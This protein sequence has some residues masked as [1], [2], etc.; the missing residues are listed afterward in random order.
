MCLQEIECDIFP[1]GTLITPCR[2]QPGAPHRLAPPGDGRPLRI[3][4]NFDYLRS[5]EGSP[6]FHLS[7]A[8]SPGQEDSL[9]SQQGDRCTRQIPSDVSTAR[10]CPGDHG[11]VKMQ[12][13]PQQEAPW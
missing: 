2:G 4:N 9:Q 5:L 11:A 1:L 7:D 6:G 12:P 3:W 13:A 10:K 8:S